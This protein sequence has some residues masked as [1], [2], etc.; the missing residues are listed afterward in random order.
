MRLHPH[1]PRLRMAHHI[2]QRFLGDAVERGVACQLRR[3]VDGD[4]GTVG[5]LQRQR[6]N[7]L[8]HTDHT[9]PNRPSLAHCLQRRDKTKL[10]QLRRPQATQQAAQAL[11]QL[12]CRLCRPLRGCANGFCLACWRGR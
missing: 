6:A 10:I 2:G 7:G 11:L 4:I 3:S 5:L 9:G 1:L 12:F 8:E